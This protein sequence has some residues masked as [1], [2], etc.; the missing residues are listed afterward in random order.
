[1]SSRI[2]RDL[3]D[4]INQR[5][6]LITVNLDI[7]KGDLPDSAS[8]SKHHLDDLME[9]MMELGKDIQALSHR[10]HSSKL[11]Q[12][13]LR[14][15][16]ASFCRE[17]ADRQKVKVQFRGDELPEDIP[18]DISLCLFRILQESLH[19]AAKY[20]GTSEFQVSIVRNS[21]SVQLT[22]RDRGKGFDVHQALNSE[23][24]G[25]VSMKERMKLVHGELWIES[26]SKVGTT[27]TA[28]APLQQ[29]SKS[30]A[31][32]GSSGA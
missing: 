22:V 8:A 31:A 1:M 30:A 23:G 10:L 20:S 9:K 24:L 2:A 28:R 21:D 4:D 27:I 15:A 16:A 11:E 7:A 29:K 3:H 13:G 18:I 5:L 19:N 14:T 6:A 32:S 17:F 25:L 26:Q 12:L